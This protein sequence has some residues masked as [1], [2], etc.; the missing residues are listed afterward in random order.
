MQTANTYF[1]LPD[2]LISSIDY[3]LDHHSLEVSRSALLKL[4]L[5]LPVKLTPRDNARAIDM[6]DSLIRK[7]HG[8]SH[9][10]ALRCKHHLQPK[11]TQTQ[12]IC[13]ALI[14]LGLAND[15]IDPTNEDT[16]LN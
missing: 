9:S 12:Q 6:A 15:I 3:Y 16:I 4:C 5:T 1:N 11:T 10:I 14:V 8:R 13:R 2:Y 7:S